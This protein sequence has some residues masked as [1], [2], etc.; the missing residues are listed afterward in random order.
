MTFEECGSVLSYFCKVFEDIVFSALGC[1][2]GYEI[3]LILLKVLIK[4]RKEK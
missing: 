4:Y 3:L 2:A 1:F